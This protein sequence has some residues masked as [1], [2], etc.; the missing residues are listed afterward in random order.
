MHSVSIKNGDLSSWDCDTG[1]LSKGITE[2]FYVASV[3]P[4]GCAKSPVEVA[5][6]L[7]WPHRVA[8]SIDRQLSQSYLGSAASAIARCD[9]F[10]PGSA[11]QVV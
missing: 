1:T 11:I 8:S 5:G 6:A 3:D 2:N 7:R 4:K 9:L 10:Y